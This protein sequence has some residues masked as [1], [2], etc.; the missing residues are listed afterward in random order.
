MP[1]AETHRRLHDLF[2]RRNWDA[3]D[4]HMREDMAY[5]DMPRG[6]TMK[7]LGGFKGWLGEWT[8]GFSDAAVTNVQY[9]DGQDFTVA[10]FQGQGTNDGELGQFGASGE[11]MDMPFCE[12]LHYDTDGRVESGEIY[13]DQMTMMTQLGH[14]EPPQ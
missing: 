13:Y 6:I 12:I 2:N 3:M 1:N 10:R 11:R 9:L 14:A 4:E 8:T 5:T 7:S